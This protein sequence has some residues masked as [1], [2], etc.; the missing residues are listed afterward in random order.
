LELGK[1][2]HLYEGDFFGIG[3]QEM[4]IS[5]KV[6]PAEETEKEEDSKGMNVFDIEDPIK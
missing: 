1:N 6:E 2:P 4:G 3:K 5:T